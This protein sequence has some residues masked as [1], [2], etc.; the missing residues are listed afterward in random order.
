MP[1]LYG[2]RLSVEGR[3][4]GVLELFGGQ[5]AEATVQA[6]V[7]VPVDPSGGGV[8]D[9]GRGPV[10]AGVEDGGADALGLVQPD[11]A[12]HQGVIERVA[13]RSDR[14]PSALECE[15]LG[16]A[17]RCA[18]RRFKGSRQHRCSDGPRVAG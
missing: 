16:E 13:D 7:V 15:V 5:V 17:N 8:F 18:L 9:I 1:L 11:H 12:L 3:V 10:G 2:L 6:P 4:V 14:R